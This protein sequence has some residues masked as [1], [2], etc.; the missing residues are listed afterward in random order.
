MERAKQQEDKVMQR[1]QEIQQPQLLLTIK[2]VQRALGISRSM[3]YHLVQRGELRVIHI[4]TAIRVRQ[5][6]IRRFLQACEAA[7]QMGQRMNKKR[8]AKKQG[9]RSHE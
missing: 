3:V 7:E 2:Q 9:K 6:E 4:G 8:N 5:S 1:E